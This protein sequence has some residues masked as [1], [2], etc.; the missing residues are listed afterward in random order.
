MSHYSYRCTAVA[1]A[2]LLAAGSAASAASPA[3]LEALEEGGHLSS[4][5]VE[6][7]KAE[8]HPAVTPMGDN[9]RNFQIRGMIQTQA[10]YVNTNTGDDENWSTLELRRA[11]LGVEGDLLQDVR[12][13]LEG[14][15]AFNEFDDDIQPLRS[16]YLQW[17]KHDAAHVKVGF[18]R[19]AFGLERTTGSAKLL[20]I[21]RSNA[22]QTI[23]DGDMLGIALDG[24]LEVAP[25][26][27]YSAGIYTNRQNTNEVNEHARYLYN[28]SGR[29]TLD[30]FMPEGHALAARLDFIFND[31]RDGDAVF[32]YDRGIAFGLHYALN[33]LDIRA[34]IL[35]AETDG[36]E[37]VFGW[38]V[39]PAFH[40]TEQFQGVLRYEMV[41]SDLNMTAPS[42]YA[43]H[44]PDLAGGFTGADYWALYAGGNYYI[45]GDAHK[46]MAGLEYSELDNGM[47]LE[48]TTVMGAWRVLF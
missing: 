3:L 8:G 12:V 33:E 44:V 21:E 25:L 28:L 43:A 23:I 41:D 18:D 32:M 4:E 35:W 22:T 7:I 38:Y 27:S 20:T 42:R 17:R 47:T 11:R 14:N 10:A 16:A 36:S 34:E 2:S 45:H 5:Q 26:F 40:F 1:V 39:Q 6:R 37:D 13:N 19:P 15:F 24:S 46:L 9:F 30:D 29:M 48:A 31:D